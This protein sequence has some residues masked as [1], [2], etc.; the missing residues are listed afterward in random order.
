VLAC[1]GLGAGFRWDLDRSPM[2][3][4]QQLVLVDTALS[5]TV[6]RQPGTKQFLGK[7]KGCLC[8]VPDGG[9]PLYAFVLGFHPYLPAPAETP[10][11]TGNCTKKRGGL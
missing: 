10:G 3:F 5:A 6:A 1:S 2:G 9:R 4:D 8:C 11:Q 7:G